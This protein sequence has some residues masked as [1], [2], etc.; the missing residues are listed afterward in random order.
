L[1]AGR[2]REATDRFATQALVLPNVDP[3]DSDAISI[4][5]LPAVATLCQAEDASRY[6]VI[7]AMAAD[8]F[9]ETSR[10]V[11]AEQI[12]KACLL[13]P[14]PAELMMKLRPP[15]ERL[16]HAILDG[17]PELVGSPSRVAWSCFALGL[18]HYRQ[19]DLASAHAWA[20]RCLNEAGVNPSRDAS[21][22]C[23]LAM[24]QARRG[25]AEEAGLQFA[26]AR[27]TIDAVFARNLQIGGVNSFW[28]DWVAAR[29]FLR[30]ASVAT[31]R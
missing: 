2:W 6:A 9:A 23:L 22:R 14:A 11:V 20:V 13:T 10:P 27:T 4:T 7:R 8:R 24:V 31:G 28:F 18:F 26:T 17:H 29:V 16:E 15:A 12:L 3:S 19:G 1:L 25:Y 5:L 30:E 21:A